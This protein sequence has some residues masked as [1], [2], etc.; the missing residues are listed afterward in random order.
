M[1]HRMLHML[2]RCF[3]YAGSTKPAVRECRSRSKEKRRRQTAKI[4]KSWVK[5]REQRVRSTKPKQENIFTFS[6]TTEQ[7][8]KRDE[9]RESSCGDGSHE[10]EYRPTANYHS[11]VRGSASTTFILV[12]Y[13]TSI[14]LLLL[15][16][17][18]APYPPRLLSPQPSASLHSLLYK[19]KR[20]HHHRKCG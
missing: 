14:Y 3:I 7:R 4:K 11:H 16:L 15:T 2:Q 9:V 1:L 8:T 10:K 12:F 19:H 5:C 20:K 6:S 18:F 17:G 13:F